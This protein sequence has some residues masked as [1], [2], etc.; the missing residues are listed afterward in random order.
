MVPSCHLRPTLAIVSIVNK[1]EPGAS[2]AT[3]ISV[4]LCIPPAFHT[5]GIF[6]ISHRG[7]I[8]N[9]LHNS[10]Y[11]QIVGVNASSKTEIMVVGSYSVRCSIAM[12]KVHVFELGI[13]LASEVVYGDI[14][15]V[16]LCAIRIVT[17]IRRR[18]VQCRSTNVGH[19]HYEVTLVCH[20]SIEVGSTV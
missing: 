12:S 15:I 18:N 17:R 16:C 7:S 6:Q 14:A 1:S 10:G 20:I 5:N 19:T 3:K 2:I 8:S 9:T 13:R 11:I 4:V